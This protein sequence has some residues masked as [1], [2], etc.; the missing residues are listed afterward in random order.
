[1]S[2]LNDLKIS[3]Q[4]E[5]VLNNGVNFIGC[6]SIFQLYILEDIRLYYVL[7]CFKNVLVIVY[8]YKEIN[9]QGQLEVQQIHLGS[10][11]FGVYGLVQFKL[12]CWALPEKRGHSICLYKQLLLSQFGIRLNNF[13]YS[14]SETRNVRRGVDK[15]T[16]QLGTETQRKM[17]MLWIWITSE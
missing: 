13:H 4:R 5:G 14:S 10:F 8:I 15:Q 3:S 6:F 1:M 11:Q 16:N 7:Q 12:L 17:S 9:I 2:L